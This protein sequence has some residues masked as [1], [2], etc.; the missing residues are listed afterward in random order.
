MSY[1]GSG[2]VDSDY[3]FDMISSYV[4]LIK[5]KMFKDAETVL[6][7]AY[8]EQSL[9]AS[10]RCL[11]KLCAEFPKCVRLQF[12]RAD[13]RRC[14]ELFDAWYDAAGDQLPKEHA[15]QIRLV[16][17]AEFALFRDEVLNPPQAPS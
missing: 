14:E 4:F 3:A 2:P 6:Q 11:R 7:K 8:P 15:S 5:Q 17:T 1:W 13:L 10:L 12:G 16:A 9:I